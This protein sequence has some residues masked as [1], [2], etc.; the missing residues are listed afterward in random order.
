[1]DTPDNYYAVLGVPIDADSETLKRAYRQLARRY[2]PDVAGSAGAIQMKRINRAYDV[3]SDPEKRLN[4]DTILGGVIDFR[5]GG[6]S[7]PRQRPHKFD[8][9]DDLEFSGLSI[10]STKGPLKTGPVLRTSLGVISSLSSL[11][12]PA[13]FCIAV[14]TLDGKGLLWHTESSTAQTHFTADPALTIESLRA[15]RFSVQGELLAGWGRLGLHI[16]NVKDGRLLWSYPLAQRAVSAYYSL[17]VALKDTPPDEQVGASPETLSKPL[18]C[19]EEEVEKQRQFW[20]IRLRAL[21]QDARTLLTLSCA[22]VPGEADEMAVARRWD[23]T[24][25]A[26]ISG[27]ARPQITSSVVIGRCIE[28]TPPYAV[29]PNATTLA[30][31]YSGRKVRLYDTLSGMYSEVPGGT[32]GG[33]AKLALSPDAQWLAVAREDSEVNEGVVDL[34]STGQGQIVQKLYHP[35]QISAL[36]FSE[37]HLIVALTDGTIQV[38]Q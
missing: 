3:L 27:K 17:D 9:A 2:H 35:W 34:W 7:R 21:A 19:A 1:M 11:P 14:G 31:V 10:F 28:Y 5:R 26:R 13:G 29:T 25:R 23:L 15:L 24:A 33:S 36:H 18:I 38:W 32:M 30:L 16:W 20:A 22:H 8:P 4:Y 6:L 12:T 37:K